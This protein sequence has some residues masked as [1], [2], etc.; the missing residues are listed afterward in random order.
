[1]SKSIKKT[2]RAKVDILAEQVCGIVYDHLTLKALAEVAKAF[3]DVAPIKHK[4]S[5]LNTFGF[6]TIS[7]ISRLRDRHKTTVFRWVKEDEDRMIE[8]E[9]YIQHGKW[10]Y[11]FLTEEEETEE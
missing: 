11:Y 2:K 7:Q 4:R 10:K 9:H 6:Y 8:G 5:V 1:M 3:L